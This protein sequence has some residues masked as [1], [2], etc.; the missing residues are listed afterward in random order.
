MSETENY[1]GKT[2]EVPIEQNLDLNY[3]V[4]EGDARTRLLEVEDSSIDLIVTSPPYGGIKNYSDRKGEIGWNQDFLDYHESLLEVFRE[5]VRV[6]KPG[7]RFVINI[8]DEFVPSTKEKPYHV[9]P[10]ASQIIS[11]II[12]EYPDTMM[13]NGCIHWQKITTSNTSGGGKIM[14]SVYHPRNGHFFVN[15][16]HIMVFKKTGKSKNPPKWRKEAS[17]FTLDERRVWFSDTWNFTPERQVNHVAMYPLELPNRIIQMY[18]FVGDQV[19]DPFLGS[20]TTLASAMKL[21]RSCVGV[22]LGFGEGETW[23]DII[24]NKVVPFVSDDH[25]MDF[26]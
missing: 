6:L 12:N 9:I 18:S 5:C 20:G 22:E 4:M 25:K 26:I 21:K 15:Y 11:N 14:G 19:L 16:E 3:F 17:K 2:I 13:F 24:R 8:G 23:K 10:H 7:C 1:V